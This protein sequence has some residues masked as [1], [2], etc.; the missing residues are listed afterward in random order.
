MPCRVTEFQK[1]QWRLQ[2]E[3]RAA[4]QREQQRVA[5]LQNQWA[6]VGAARAN[7]VLAGYQQRAHSESVQRLLALNAFVNKA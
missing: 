3:R 5:N 2:E 6:Q 1:Q 7:A 4:E